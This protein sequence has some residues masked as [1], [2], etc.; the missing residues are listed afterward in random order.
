MNHSPPFAWPEGKRLERWALVAGGA[1]L[2][3][4]GLGALLD[5]G[6]FFHSYLMAWFGWLGISLGSL[7]IWMLHN[8]VG[9]VW[10]LVIRRLLEAATRVLPLLLLLFLPILFGLAENYPWARPE[11]TEEIP[12]P[13]Y[14]NVPFFLIR[15]AIYFAVWLIMVWLLN[16]WS[17]ENDRT[18]DPAP[19]LRSQHLS[20]PGLILFGLTVTFAAV[21]W[22]MSLEPKWY[23]T[24]FGLVVATGQLLPGMGLAIAVAACLPKNSYPEEVANSASWND[25]GNLLLAFVMLWTYM[26]FA[27]LLLIW[28]GNLAEEI[29][30][31]L[32]R[33]QGGWQWIGVALA[34]FYFALPFLLLLSRDIK[35]HPSRLRVVAGAVVVVSF[36]HQF[37]LIAP[38]FSPGEF[39]IHWL[40]LAAFV[41]VGGLWLGWFLHQLQTRPLVPVYDPMAKEVLHHAGN[42]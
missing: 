12:Q 5:T 18:D 3:L 19:A 6:Q 22:V 38:A 9:G 28:S 1:G 16:H 24:I 32:D 23:S 31:Y 7:A 41:G 37:W 4:S 13:D 42:S 27:Q 34:V 21:D 17:A 26:A 11:G 36:V 15:T 39:R 20:G 25:L 8:M 29:P 30:W 33:S 2:V 10:G 35:R 14:L 40:D